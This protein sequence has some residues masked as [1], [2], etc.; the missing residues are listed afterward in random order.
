[1]GDIASGAVT[2]EIMSGNFP[3]TPTA[4]DGQNI[5]EK[6][7]LDSQNYIGALTE[8]NQLLKKG[9]DDVTSKLS[10][11]IDGSLRTPTI[12]PTQTNQPPFDINTAVRNVIAENAMNDNRM[13]EAAA[14]KFN[15]AFGNKAQEV[16][17]SLQKDKDP[18]IQNSLG[19]VDKMI[20]AGQLLLKYQTPMGQIPP[21]ANT[22]MSQNIHT[23][24][25]KE[26]FEAEAAEAAKKNPKW[27]DSPDYFQKLQAVHGKN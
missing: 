10:S 11:F 23:G 5:I 22:G 24:L 6:R 7:L 26:S 12:T 8:Q 4:G 13:R 20:L 25:T 16:F 27:F 21:H 2:G 1:M 14:A 19:D 3:I 15:S 18:V 17:T 9:L